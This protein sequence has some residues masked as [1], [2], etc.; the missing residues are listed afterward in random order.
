MNAVILAPAVLPGRDVLG[1]R[2]L[3]AFLGLTFLLS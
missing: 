1:P 3:V 2:A